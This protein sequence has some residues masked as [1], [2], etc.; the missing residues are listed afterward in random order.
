MSEY[1]VSARKY[2]PKNFEDV[3]GQSHVTKT[4]INAISNNQISHA[5]IFC[6]PRGVGKT[7]CA[8]IFANKINNINIDK[9]QDGIFNIF[10]L[11]AASNNSVDDIRD[12]VAQTRIPPQ[13]GK[14]KVYIIDEVHML[15]KAAFNAFLKTLEEPPKY[16]VFILATTEKQ[17]LIPTI[18]SRCQIF[19]FHRINSLDIKSHL[20]SLVEKEK[21]TVDE[22]SIKLIAESA[23]G[24]LRDALS[25]FDKIISFCGKN[26]NHEDVEILLKSLNPKR[27]LLFIEKIKNHEINETLIDFNNLIEKG[28]EGK[29]LVISLIEFYRNI[30]LCK[31]QSSIEIIKCDSE[32][33]SHLIEL[34]K[35]ISTEKIL[36]Y[37]DILLESQK[38]YNRSFNQRF[39]VELCLMQLCSIDNSTKKKNIIDPPNKFDLKKKNEET[40]SIK[41]IKEVDE[42][43]VKNSEDNS[44]ISEQKKITD[45]NNKI[46]Q[47]ILEKSTPQNDIK[48]IEDPI[49]ESSI[50]GKTIQ[51][52]LE[53]DKPTQEKKIEEEKVED[54]ISLEH[55]TLQPHWLELCN[56]LK[57][58]GKMNLYSTLL[59]QEKVQIK[60]N[61]I[62]IKVQSET[63]KKE[64]LD[65]NNLIV[66]FLKNYTKV[67]YIKLIVDLV[68]FKEDQ[69]L[70]TN[71]D[72]LK[73]IINEKPSVIELIKKLNLEIKE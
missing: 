65:N 63:Q 73:F 62:E 5:Y 16:C 36:N 56:H 59:N 26:W 3:V 60:D 28:F 34:S 55:N 48:K 7:T 49:L 69:L 64:I 33:K 45:I 66:D 31:N 39:L 27:V 32:T 9:K 19:E 57:N 24:A 13:N 2:R 17:K 44:N 40:V 22:K 53:N 54:L 30:M 35:V 1:L 15:S 43:D 10:E 58:S 42:V 18:L 20:F 61:V 6:G 67:N 4:L 51:E 8:R 14:Y 70:Y 47:K 46:D 23:D 50:L 71:E 25:T 21:L 12:L 41:N 52:C 11:D 29:D 72:K 68:K 37:L 38:Q